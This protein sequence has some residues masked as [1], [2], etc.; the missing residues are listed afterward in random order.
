MLIYLCSADLQHVPLP[1][2]TPKT[3]A[4]MSHIKELDFPPALPSRRR[5]SAAPECLLN[6][7]LRDAVCFPAPAANRGQQFQ[8][9][10]SS[11][12][13][14]KELHSNRPAGQSCSLEEREHQSRLSGF[15][16]LLRT[17]SRLFAPAGVTRPLSSWG[18]GGGS[19]VEVPTEPSSSV[20]LCC[21]CSFV[22]CS[23]GKSKRQS[24]RR[25]AEQHRTSGRSVLLEEAAGA[26]V[27]LGRPVWPVSSFNIG[28]GR[29]SGAAG[30]FV[31][32][33]TL[34]TAY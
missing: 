28:G 15:N 21:C 11:R 6:N 9:C 18:G 23:G 1:S 5:A 25:R 12:R 14:I 16:L 32:K 31:I 34:V 29:S 3:C 33:L 19:R 26:S 30:P 7:C 2:Y 8:M 22:S 10:C 20:V 27:V 4:L 17:A 24:K 13:I